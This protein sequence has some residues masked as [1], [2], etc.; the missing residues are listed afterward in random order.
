MGREYRE[1]IWTDDIAMHGQIEQYGG[2]QDTE[3][4]I[5]R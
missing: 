5:G 1:D 4:H 2:A 3:L